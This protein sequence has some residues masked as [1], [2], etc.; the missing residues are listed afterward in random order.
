MSSSFN[1]ALIRN[2]GVSSISTSGCMCVRGVV[3]CSRFT[4]TDESAV[5]AAGLREKWRER[6]ASWEEGIGVA[7][8][9]FGFLP[10]DDGVE[11]VSLGEGNTQVYEGRRCAEYCGLNSLKLKHQGN[12]PTGSFKDTGMTVAVTQAK[13]LGVE[14]VVRAPG[15]RQRV[16]RRMRRG[17]D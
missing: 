17:P 12:N 10:F 11:V 16:W 8:G 14:R 6:R 3:I 9:G 15:T 7:C 2:V 13:K 1:A 5:D 4:I